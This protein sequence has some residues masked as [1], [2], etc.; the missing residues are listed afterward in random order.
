[1]DLDVLYP[2]TPHSVGAKAH[3]NS[4]F[5]RPEGRS[6]SIAGTSMSHIGA[7]GFFKLADFKDCRD[8]LL[9]SQLEAYVMKT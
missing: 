8:I 1:M 6:Q 9:F 3:L 2:S 7:T 5:L 4:L